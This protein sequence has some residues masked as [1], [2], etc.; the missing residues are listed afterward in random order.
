MNETIT[1]SVKPQAV[2]EEQCCHISLSWTRDKFKLEED[3][4]LALGSLPF[5]DRAT[6]AM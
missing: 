2:L 6:V 1:E 4:E 3:L 5:T